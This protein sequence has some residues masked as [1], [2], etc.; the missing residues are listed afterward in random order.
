MEFESSLNAL[1]GTLV[2]LYC[3]EP[4]L[5]FS[6]SGTLLLRKAT[7]DAK[8]LVFDNN[9]AGLNAILNQVNTSITTLAVSVRRAR[10]SLCDIN[11]LPFDIM[12]TIFH[13]ATHSMRE[14]FTDYADWATLASHHQPLRL[15]QVCSHWRAVALEQRT[16]WSILD[17][18]KMSKFCIQLFQQRSGECPLTIA[19]PVWY[20]TRWEGFWVQPAMGHRIKTLELSLPPV[21][22]HNSA[23]SLYHYSSAPLLETLHLS[24]YG[25][26]MPLTHIF[27][28]GTPRL[29]ELH[30]KGFGIEWRSGFYKNLT[31]LCLYDSRLSCEL[32][33]RHLEDLLKM[34]GDSP[35]IERLEYSLLAYGRDPNAQPSENSLH[36][37][38][39]SSAAINPTRHVPLNRLRQFRLVMPTSKSAAY[40]LER[41]TYT[42]ALQ[43]LDIDIWGTCNLADL[44]RSDVLPPWMF[45]PMHEAHFEFSP[46]RCETYTL[47]SR[48][49]LT[50]RS[51]TGSLHRSFLLSWSSESPSYEEVRDITTLLERDYSALTIQ[52]Q[53]I[54]FGALAPWANPTDLETLCASTLLLDLR[55]C[56][57]S[58]RTLRLS[59][60][61][62]TH[63][64]GLI[65][66]IAEELK[67]VK[68]YPHMATPVTYWYNLVAIEVA[69]SPALTL[70]ELGAI[71]S[72][73]EFLPKYGHLQSLTV[74]DC[75]IVAG[76]DEVDDNNGLL[77]TIFSRL[78]TL[79]HLTIVRDDKVYAASANS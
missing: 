27:P 16:L 54:K 42:D 3:A 30:I 48:F 64:S 13:F 24:N 73:A 17:V 52:S 62:S 66:M 75:T 21:G 1:M 56:S 15:S 35:N 63:T 22:A 45:L 11:R 50:Q 77:E 32:P 53:N 47:T 74:L 78:R 26:P 19:C 44:L 40:L 37:E 18:T 7:R 38:E 41:I 9:I 2:Q 25:A 39:E 14:P 60:D 36:F 28:G 34:I 6:D 10:N 55:P 70:R 5:S 31:T 43:H 61:D 49:G 65:Q 29:R 4:C 69:N 71:T 23:Q 57:A 76:E 68:L 12:H 72:L 20:K 33:E 79:P 58:V 8:M 51:D 46:G 67:L 59:L